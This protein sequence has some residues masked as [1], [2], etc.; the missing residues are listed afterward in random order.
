MPAK[1]NANTDEVLKFFDYGF[2]YGGKAA[3]ELDYVAL[4]K[5]LTDRIKK[6]VWT[7]IKK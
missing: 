3:S 1:G 4:P 5:E 6:E 2:T 7:T